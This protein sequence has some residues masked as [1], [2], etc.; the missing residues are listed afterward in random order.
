[1]YHAKDGLFFEVLPFGDVHIIVTRDGKPPH[2]MSANTAFETTISRSVLGSIMAFACARGY[3]S[4]TFYEA[5]GMLQLP[6]K[7]TPT[8]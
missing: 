4:E 7:D 6:D 5:Y 3:T 8:L 1:M 2:A